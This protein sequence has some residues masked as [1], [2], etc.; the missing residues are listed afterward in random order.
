MVLKYTKINQKKCVKI[1]KSDFFVI[2][3]DSVGDLGKLF[4]QW[5]IIILE[6]KSQKN[7]CKCGFN[8]IW[9]YEKIFFSGMMNKNV[10]W[11]DVDL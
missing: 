3:G 10:L 1:P 5:Y 2:F 9:K 11:C 7:R 4:I 6:G 8:I